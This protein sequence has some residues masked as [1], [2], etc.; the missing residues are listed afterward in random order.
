[1]DALF[2]DQPKCF[3]L[4]LMHLSGLTISIGNIRLLNYAS[5]EEK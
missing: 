2:S 3:N 5:V 1:M 4:I